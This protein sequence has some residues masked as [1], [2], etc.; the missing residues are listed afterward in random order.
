ML[1][2]FSDTLHLHVK[3]YAIWRISQAVK[4]KPK[5]GDTFCPTGW[6]QISVSGEEWVSNYINWWSCRFKIRDLKLGLKYKCILGILMIQNNEQFQQL[7]AWKYQ[8]RR[9]L[10]LRCFGSSSFLRAKSKIWC[11]RSGKGC[12]SH[13]G[14]F[15]RGYVVGVFF[16]PCVILRR[17]VCTGLFA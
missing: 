8:N 9:W 13:W 4:K 7:H 5:A 1:V 14:L 11:F 2:Y 12:T 3:I 6:S 17:L 10:K 15:S 16:L